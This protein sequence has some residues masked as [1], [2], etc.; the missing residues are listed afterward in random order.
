MPASLS[1]WSVVKAVIGFVQE[2]KAKAA[3]GSNFAA[4]SAQ[5]VGPARWRAMIDAAD[6]SWRQSADA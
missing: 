5:G 2:G 1:P 4:L 6:R 3:L